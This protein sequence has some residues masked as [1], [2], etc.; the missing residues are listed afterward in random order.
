[1][2]IMVDIETLG[3][4]R[5][6]A[7]VSIGAV[8][9]SASSI[10]QPEFYVEIGFQHH[11]AEERVIDDDTVAWWGEQPI[12]IREAAFA[13]RDMGYKEALS[14]FAEFVQTNLGKK[15]SIWANGV[16]FDFNILNDA[17]SQFYIPCPWKR[18]QECCMRSLRHLEP[19]LENHLVIT[20]YSEMKKDRQDMHNA[21]ADAKCQAEYVLQYM[22]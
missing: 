15:A 4:E 14:K 9:F 5:K 20:R 22:R 13:V 6:A 3:T 18:R 2:H 16:S 17:M 10:K 7:I 19:F 21:L 11:I 1:M 12:E 8:G